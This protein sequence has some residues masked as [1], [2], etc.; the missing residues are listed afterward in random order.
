VSTSRRVTVADLELTPDDGNR[1][2]IIDGE[3]HVST[4]PNVL[5]QDTSI[6]FGAALFNWSSRTD[7]GRVLGAPG[8]IFAPDDAVAPD[9]VWISHEWYA[10]AINPDGKLHAAPELV[11]EILSPGRDNEERDRDTKLR[12]YSRYGLRE[13]WIADCRDR[14]VHVFRRQDVALE[15]VAKLTVGDTLTSPLLPGFAV[16]MHDLF[17]P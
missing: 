13:Y 9:I 3:L 14:T 10:R 5:H 2:E 1:Y 4:Q 6:R 11:V 17:P 16:P 8:I 12:L 15:A 7:M